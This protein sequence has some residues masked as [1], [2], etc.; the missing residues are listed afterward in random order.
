MACWNVGDDRGCAGKD[1]ILTM[2][3]Q[4][5]LSKSH[6]KWISRNIR[7]I[8]CKY[9]G[10]SRRKISKSWKLLP[11]GRRLEKRQFFNKKASTISLIICMYY[12][13]KFFLTRKGLWV[14]GIIGILAWKKSWFY[15]FTYT[16]YQDL[17][18]MY[19]VDK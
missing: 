1:R 12:L 11:L 8:I 7:N 19:I 18:G 6:L 14:A 2:I 13:D 16:G 3:W 5:E 4:Q 17:L 10:S 15:N 9:G